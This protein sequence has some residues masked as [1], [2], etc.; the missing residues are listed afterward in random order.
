MPHLIAPQFCVANGNKIFIL[1]DLTVDPLELMGSICLSFSVARSMICSRLY[2]LSE[3]MKQ[4]FVCPMLVC[5]TIF[6]PFV[7]SKYNIIPHMS[8]HLQW[9]IKIIVSLRKTMQKGGRKKWERI[10]R[11]KWFDGLWNEITVI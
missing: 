1:I 11:V 6:I 7:I 8:L 4:F 9:H 10:S 2:S 3:I 5:L